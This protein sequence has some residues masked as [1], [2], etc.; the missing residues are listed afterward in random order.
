MRA[1]LSTAAGATAVTNVVARKR[2]F[3]TD[4]E[5]P[6]LGLQAGRVRAAGRFKARPGAATFGACRLHALSTAGLH[7]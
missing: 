1:G 2:S 6:R 5:C 4:P 7:K 3:E